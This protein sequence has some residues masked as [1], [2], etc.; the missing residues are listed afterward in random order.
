MA[1]HTRRGGN[2]VKKISSETGRSEARP[3]TGASPECPD[4]LELLQEAIEVERDHLSKAESVLGCLAVAME[5]ST[6]GVDRPYYPD[7][8]Q[9]AR[10][11]VK[12]SVNRLDP[13]VLADTARRMR[14]LIKDETHMSYR[15]LAGCLLTLDYHPSMASYST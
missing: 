4:Q 8:A 9:L 10:E 12:G 14:G 11:M 2:K 15:Y 6:D 1:K 3:A 5:Y 7:V 13:L